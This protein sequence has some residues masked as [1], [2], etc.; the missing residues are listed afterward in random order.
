MSLQSALQTRRVG[1]SVA[2]P[3]RGCHRYL[4]PM[5]WRCS[6]RPEGRQNPPHPCRPHRRPSP[7]TPRSTLG[8]A[9]PW[10][11]VQRRLL[12]SL[13]SSGRLP[14]HRFTNWAV[15]ALAL[16]A[17]QREELPDS[18]ILLGVVVSHR[19]ARRANSPPA[20]HEHQSAKQ[21][22]LDRHGVEPGHVAGGVFAFR[23][24]AVGL[25]HAKRIFL[26]VPQVQRNV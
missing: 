10:C 19:L 24:D 11:L 15:A 18:V 4:P 17:Q 23:V 14:S 21:V 9:C 12:F 5:S 22:A 20:P 8:L 25:D 26:K 1:S 6:L 3:R 16:A 2:E 7:S 13:G